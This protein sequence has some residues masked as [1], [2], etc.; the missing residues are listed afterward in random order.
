MG[1]SELVSVS[2][3]NLSFTSQSAFSIDLCTLSIHPFLM[4]SMR[5]RVCF[6]QRRG[7]KESSRGFCV[8]I[9]KCVCLIIFSKC[10]HN[11]KKPVGNILFYQEQLAKKR[12]IAAYRKHFTVC[13]VRVEVGWKERENTDNRLKR[14]VKKHTKHCQSKEKVGNTKWTRDEEKSMDIT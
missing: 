5:M 12:K 10:L 2:L 9:C 1:S 11:H 13:N 3:W 4:Y 14:G 8:S 7:E 6:T